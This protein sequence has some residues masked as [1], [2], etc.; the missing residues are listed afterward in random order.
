MNELKL[1]YEDRVCEALWM[2][3]VGHPTIG[4]IAGICCTDTVTL[5]TLLIL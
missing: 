3:A 5:V 2:V 4:W 1:M